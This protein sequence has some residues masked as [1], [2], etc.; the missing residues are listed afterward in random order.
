LAVEGPLA[1]TGCCVPKGKG[2]SEPATCT[3]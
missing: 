3:V 2:A 1:Q